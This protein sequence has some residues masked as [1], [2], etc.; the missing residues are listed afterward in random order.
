M[1]ALVSVQQFREELRAKR[2]PSGG[3]Y[4][5]ST[6]IQPKAAEDGSR[7]IRF[8]FS[9]ESVDRMGDTIAVNGWNLS[10]FTRNPVAL[11][12][13][14]SSAPPIG[15]AENVGPEGGRL[16]GD[17][18]FA[19]P[20]TYLFADT[21]YRLVLGKFLNAVSVGFMPTEHQW[22]KDDDRE[23]GIDFLKQD[24]LEISVCPVPANQNAL[25]EAR[26]KGIDT[27]PLV[28]WAERTLDAGGKIAISRS[29]LERLRKAAKETPMAHRPHAPRRRA[30]GEDEPPPGTCGRDVE[31]DCGMSNPE[32][33][34]VHGKTKEVG[35]D[36][37]DEKALRRALKR[38]RRKDGNTDG[39]EPPVAHE[40]AIRMAHKSLRTSKAFL[41][42]AA[43][44][45]AK[46]EDLLAGVVA[47][48]NENEDDENPDN[49]PPADP[50]P[51]AEPDKAKQLRRAA[52][53]RKRLHQ[54]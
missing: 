45:H 34:S 11:W 52:A 7:R 51:D 13:H 8:C 31:T 27:R 53:L 44:Y 40:D 15:R 21:I 17:I 4:R 38:L 42:E 19:P 37:D 26:A 2:V 35:V 6:A 22:S 50:D 41:T 3:V 10:D 24:L 32:E 5:V 29:E 54:A 39:D 33:C 43:S 49:D 20:E 25:A 1:S 36:P 18:D 46:A 30:A 23:W 14:D 9:D 28:E 47:A 12:A 16:M 48:L